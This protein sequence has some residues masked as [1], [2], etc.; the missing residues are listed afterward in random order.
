MVAESAIC[1]EGRGDQWTVLFSGNARVL[2]EAAAWLMVVA[3]DNS[4]RLN[5]LAPRCS[6]I[7]HALFLIPAQS[8]P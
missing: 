1:S 8:V 3:V 7:P 2:R 6:F 5:A 4:Y